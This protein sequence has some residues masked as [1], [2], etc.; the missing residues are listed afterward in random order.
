MLQKIRSNLIRKES[1]NW[2]YLK[3]ELAPA[4]AWKD[5]EIGAKSSLNKSILKIEFVDSSI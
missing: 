4:E 3:Y 1:S 5:I 2:Q